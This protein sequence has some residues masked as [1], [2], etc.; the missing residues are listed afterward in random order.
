MSKK[1]VLKSKE[2]KWVTV[3]IKYTIPDS[4]IARFTT[5]IVVQIIKNE[6][7]ISF[8]EQNLPI[9]L[10]EKSKPPTEIQANCVASVIVTADRLPGFIEVLQRQLDIVKKSTP[11][12]I[13]H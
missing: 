1:K 2:V 7:K 12:K 3:P 10:D 4:I 8:F 5:N 11:K 6:F 13:T 9:N